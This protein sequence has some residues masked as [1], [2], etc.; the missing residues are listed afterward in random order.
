M[1][2][3]ASKG[4]MYPHQ[5]AF[6]DGQ[7]TTDALLYFEHFATTALA[8][9]NHVS[10]LSL[11]FEKAY[12]GIG[13]HVVLQ[14]LTKWQIGP[15]IFNFVKSFLSNRTF[16]VRLNNKFSNTY[17]LFNGTPQGSPLSVVLFIIAFDEVNNILQN[18]KRISHVIYADDVL[19]FTKCKDLTVIEGDF[20]QILYKITEWSNTSGAKLSYNK[21]KIFHICNKRLCPPLNLSY[22]NVNIPN[23]HSL[24][25]LTR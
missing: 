24:R 2:F 12:D 10:T 13:A 11:D 14:Q 3:A 5:V 15:K 6:K 9:K 25:I 19:V 21:C 20:L 4:L 7:G 1:W 22:N 18:H 17:K 16:S 23:C 8:T